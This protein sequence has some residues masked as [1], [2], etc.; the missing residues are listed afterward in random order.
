MSARISHNEVGRI[1]G[2]LLKRPEDAFRSPSVIE[3]QWR[4]LG[5]TACPDFNA[6]R[7]EYERFAA[8]VTDGVDVVHYLPQDDRT[9][10]DSL[11]IRDTLVATGGGVI[12]CSMGKAARCGEPDAIADYLTANDIPILG[13]I[14]GEGRLE[15]GDLIWLDD[16]TIAVG[17]GYRTNREGIHQLRGMVSDFVDQVIVVPLPHWNGPGDVMHLM[18]LISPIDHDLAVVYSRLL[19]VPFRQH[20]L[21]R[22]IRLIE[23]PD[24]EFD[25]MGCNVLALAPRNCLMLA[26][27]PQ[28][29]ALL[30]AEG[31]LIKEYDGNEI[32]RK[33]AGGPTCLTRPLW[34]D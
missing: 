27:N 11:Y 13:R 23:V 21:N 12:L 8:L 1:R 3:E 29:K 24:S 6:A 17:Q 28:T 22:E 10:L 18:S 33:G 14:T 26:G 19:P 34:R 15:G 31:A 2:I 16:R 5:Y 30:E 9:G 20:L 32:S 25:S 4:S 7:G